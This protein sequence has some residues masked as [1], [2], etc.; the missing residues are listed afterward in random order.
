VDRLVRAADR[1]FLAVAFFPTAG[2][3]TTDA[4][5]TFRM[6]TVPSAPCRDL[7]AADVLEPGDCLE[8]SLRPEDGVRSLAVIPTFHS[9]TLDLSSTLTMVARPS[10][11]APAICFECGPKVIAEMPT[12]IVIVHW[13]WPV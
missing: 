9:L 12:P 5:A 7:P 13:K 8:P 11:N 6:T 2:C 3:L 1:D 4:S 10:I